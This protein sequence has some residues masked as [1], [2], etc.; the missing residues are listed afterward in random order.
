LASVNLEQAL[1]LYFELL[2]N[3]RRRVRS[4]KHDDA[5]ARFYRFMEATEQLILL[6]EHGIDVSRFKESAS[7]L[8]RKV[9]RLFARE[10]RSPFLLIRTWEALF[11]TPDFPE[12]LSLLDGWKLLNEL[13]P[14]IKKRGLLKEIQKILPVRNRGILAHGWVPIREKVIKH[15]DDVATKCQQI[16]LAIFNTKI[17][18]LKD[19]QENLEF[20]TI[21]ELS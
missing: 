7:K 18:A 13:D 1:I 20:V 14:E 2:N 12:H 3:A 8:P 15:F 9:R 6:H 19:I 21:P 16:M 5:V 10:S 4:K 17:P 11:S